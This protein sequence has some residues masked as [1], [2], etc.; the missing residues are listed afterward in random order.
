MQLF[1]GFL[2]LRIEWDTVN[3]AY[4]LALWFIVVPYAFGAEVWIN[5]IDLV[6]LA[7]GTIR[8]LR[9]ANVAIDTFIGND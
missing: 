8:A 2:V 4:L 1:F 6:A 7:D 5:H 3:R 9:F